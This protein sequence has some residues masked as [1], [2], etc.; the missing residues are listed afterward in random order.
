MIILLTLFVS[1]TVIGFSTYVYVQ[2]IQFVNEKYELK[3][4]DENTVSERLKINV[5]PMQANNKEIEYWSEDTSIATVDEDGNVTGV[6]FGE[7]IIYARSKENPSKITS[8]KVLI[9][10]DKIHKLYAVDPPEKLL[11]G[12]SIKLSFT[13]V[14]KEAKNADLVFESLN[15]FAT[16]SPDGMVTANNE[17]DGMAQILI[18]VKDNPSAKTEVNIKIYGKV[19][20]LSFD[21][22][23]EVF[24]AATEFALPKV[25]IYPEKAAPTQRCITT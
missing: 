21:D 14:P 24:D 18:Y 11:F 25:I 7:V 9:T 22:E 5:F 23:A 15:G 1:T 10:D 12:E 16:V 2:E 20:S 4:T 17:V 19:E 6:D 13:Y 3:K 8:C